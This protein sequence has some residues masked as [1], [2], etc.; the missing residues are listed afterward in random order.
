MILFIVIAVLF[1]IMIAFPFVLANSTRE[2]NN[3]HSL[4]V[5]NDNVR[6]PRYFAKA[7]RELIE[8]AL[9]SYD[10]SGEIMLSKREKLV[11]PPLPEGTI[12]GVVFVNSSFAPT[13]AH[14]FE[15]EI[16]CRADMSLPAG[17]V[18]RAAACGGALKLGENCRVIR[19]SDAEAAAEAM[20]GCELGI[21]FSSAKKLIIAAD[22]SFRRMYSPEIF[23]G[24]ERSGK[25]PAEL[26]PCEEIRRDIEETKDFEEIEGSVVCMHDFVVGEG[27]L[28]N[29]SLKS[30]KRIH[31]KRGA[32][33]AGNLIADGDIVVEDDVFIGGVVFSQRRVFLG[34]DCQVGRR[35]RIKSVVAKEGVTM[36]EG[37][38]VFGYIGGEQD[39]RTI[40]ANDYFGFISDKF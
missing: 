35:G 16:Y 25:N 29:G 21:S 1:L 15:K 28:I 2:K 23:I 39:G 31:V 19:W 24:A 11:T 34:P 38:L 7:F 13:E 33:I 18:M 27:S 40:A 32:H 22:C 5:K 12:D 10:G 6:D 9:A 36:A 3:T 20:R 37:V 17:T 4:V 8:K 30:R 26:P 14:N